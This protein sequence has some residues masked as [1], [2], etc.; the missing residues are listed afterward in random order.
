MK[1][2][3]KR[4]L[5]LVLALV[6]VAGLLPVTAFAA[7]DSSGKPTDLNNTLVLSIY[8]GSGF[9]GEPAVY[10]TSNYKNINSSFAVRSGATFASSAANQLDW[11]K[12]KKDLVQGA[13]SGNTSVWG[14]YDANG[15]KD[16]F[17]P[18]A[19]IIDRDNEI[20]MICAAK[21]CTEAEAEKYEIVWYVIK[22]QHNP[23]SGWFSR[24]TT[25]WHIDGV[26]KEKAKISINYYGNGNTS[27]NAPLGTTSHS[28]RSVHRS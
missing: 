7:V 1:K 26:I 23:G 5:S 3:L 19:S 22:L 25:E 4:G 10:G 24:A 16:Y 2:F 9:P 14:V 13:S 6:M 12:I 21:N 17:L 27:G 11:E 18:G 28:W 8:T 15:T 20:K